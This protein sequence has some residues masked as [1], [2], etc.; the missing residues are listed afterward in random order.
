MKPD[1]EEILEDFSG[2]DPVAKNVLSAIETKLEKTLPADYKE[3]LKISNGGEGSFG[4]EYLMIWAV[5]ELVEYNQ[6]YEVEKYAP[7]LLVFGS[8]GGGEAYAFDC[9]S[10]QFGGIVK[11]PFVGMDLKYVRALAPTFIDFLRRLSNG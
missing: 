5:E 2:N 8:N 1:F 4:K 9:R 3:L 10:G 7:G 11:V 6:Q